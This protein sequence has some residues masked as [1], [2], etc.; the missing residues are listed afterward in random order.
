MSNYKEQFEAA[1]KRGQTEEL[2]TAIK[3]WES[4]G[5]SLI[6]RLEA[7]TEFTS[8]DYET[9]CKCYTFSTDEGLVTCVLGAVGD[10]VLNN[11]NNLGSVF[12]IIFKGQGETTKGQRY[13]VFSIQRVIPE[14]RKN[15]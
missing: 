7:I 13:N 1:V 8:S 12:A 11:D 4:E 5:D 3:K 9:P 10:K 6:G 2:V 14:S 15:K